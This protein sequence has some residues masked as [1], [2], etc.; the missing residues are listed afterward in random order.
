MENRFGDAPS[1]VCHTWETLMLPSLTGWLVRVLL[2]FFF[3]FIRSKGP[4]QQMTRH[5]SFLILVS[6]FSSLI[7]WNPYTWALFLCILC[8]CCLL[9][10]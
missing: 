3:E 7:A 5:W 1:S 10:L 6:H 4:P 8:N 2:N 9:L